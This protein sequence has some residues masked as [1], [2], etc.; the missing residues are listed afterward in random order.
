MI[1]SVRQPSSRSPSGRGSLRG[2]RGSFRNPSGIPRHHSHREWR[3]VPSFRRQARWCIFR[4]RILRIRRNCGDPAHMP[5]R[6]PCNFR[7]CT[8]VIRRRRSQSGK[9]R[10]P[11][12]FRR[13][14][15]CLPGS[16]DS[17]H[18]G[19][20]CSVRN[21]SPLDTTCSFRMRRCIFRRRTHTG[22]RHMFHRRGT[23]P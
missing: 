8:P 18:R 13:R 2:S 14:R 3:I 12:A 5:S 7:Q 23:R 15:P 10:N 19:R 1:C 21:R 22:F 4:S 17:F 16:K 9:L 11:Q 6:N 20:T